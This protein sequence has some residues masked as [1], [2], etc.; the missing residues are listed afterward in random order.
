MVVVWGRGMDEEAL[1][2]SPDSSLDTEA[3][4]EELRRFYE[5]QVS[6][7]RESVKA[8]IKSNKY[9]FL[10]L[11][12]FHHLT[13]V[14]RVNNRVDVLTRMFE[15]AFSQANNQSFR[16]E[17]SKERAKYTGEMEEQRSKIKSFIKRFTM[18]LKE[19]NENFVLPNEETIKQM[20]MDYRAEDKQLKISLR[21]GVKLLKDWQ[22]YESFLD[23]CNDEM[24]RRVIQNKDKPEVLS[25]MERLIRRIL[26]E[27]ENLQ[28]W[29]GVT[30][31]D[32]KTVSGRLEATF[33]MMI[34]Q[35]ERVKGYIGFEIGEL[36]RLD[37]YLNEFSPD[38]QRWPVEARPTGRNKDNEI[39][40]M[41]FLTD[42]LKIL[43]RVSDNLKEITDRI[44]DED[45]KLAEGIVG[46]E[47]KEERIAQEIANITKK[48]KA[49]KRS[50]TKEEESKAQGLLG[51]TVLLFKR[52]LE[53]NR[54]KAKGPTFHKMMMETISL[55]ESNREDITTHEKL[56]EK[57]KLII[58]N[59][60][61]LYDKNTVDRFLES[62]EYKQALKEIDDFIEEQKTKEFMEFRKQ[63]TRE[64]IPL[65]RENI[66]S[67]KGLKAAMDAVDRLITYENWQKDMRGKAL[68][69]VRRRIINWVLPRKTDEQ[70]RDEFVASKYGLT[71]YLT[72]WGTAFAFKL[73]MEKMIA[74][75][76]ED[77]KDKTRQFSIFFFDID[78][79]KDFNTRY[80]H[81]HGDD[82]LRSLAAVVEATIRPDDLRFKYGG[83]E[84][85]IVFP[86]TDKEGALKAAFRIKEILSKHRFIGPGEGYWNDTTKQYDKEIGITISGALMSAPEDC[87]G[88]ENVRDVY[89][90][91][92]DRLNQE[93]IAT[94]KKGS[95]A[96]VF[97]GKFIMKNCIA[98]K[99]ISDGSIRRYFGSIKTAH[100]L[101]LRSDASDDVARA[102]LEGF[103]LKRSRIMRK[104][105]K[106]E[107]IF[108]YIRNNPIAAVDFLLSGGLSSTGNFELI[109]Q[110]ISMD[111]PY[112]LNLMCNY[113]RDEPNKPGP[114]LLDFAE[115]H[116]LLDK[117]VDKA[118]EEWFK[119][120][121]SESKNYTEYTVASFS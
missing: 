63:I 116:K 83:E 6:D 118:K 34:N 119:E 91:L 77:R 50:F 73:Q 54:N 56:Q 37:E 11:K 18:E 40:N 74:A 98:C 114:L 52:M 59:F 25:D 67:K 13:K 30:S 39:K 113:G 72:D 36:G 81:F 47:W 41:G 51:T 85:I 76:L 31:V 110:V 101:P 90:A 46:A 68:D 87:Q 58:L 48:A 22:Q 8:L 19:I 94:V 106:A 75:L 15:N 66:S 86:A 3:G 112:F 10:L 103:L 111:K 14:N 53:E 35:L 12:R 64:L 43:R 1:V 5:N 29:I 44:E 102:E 99:K 28:K 88:I 62:K 2:S 20:E 70:I 96:Q 79:F 95:R 82:V 38:G 17:G 61:N 117:N 100:V 89:V 32:I 7:F 42:R 45:V 4:K 9:M 57:L 27:V 26:Y 55:V 21:E 104:Y 108:E 115:Q 69:E 78:S 49:I 23:T 107:L 93:L 84:F 33:Q 105:V 16:F 24:L 65:L 97:R 71:D 92:M 109:K 120:I 121:V 80:G 60:E